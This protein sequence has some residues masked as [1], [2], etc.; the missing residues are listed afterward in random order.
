MTGLELFNHISI[1]LLPFCL[2]LLILVILINVFIKI[3]INI[4]SSDLEYNDDIDYYNYLNEKRKI[5]LQL[6][7]DKLKKN[8]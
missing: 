1:A 7:K 2:I 8:T 3:K 6:L 4:R 5:K